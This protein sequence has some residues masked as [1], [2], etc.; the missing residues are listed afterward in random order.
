MIKKPIL[1]VDGA[2]MYTIMHGCNLD[3]AYS[4]AVPQIANKASGVGKKRAKGD[5]L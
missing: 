2:T 4:Y 5:F 1:G 3:N